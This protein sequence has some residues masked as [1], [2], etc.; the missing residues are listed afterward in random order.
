MAKKDGPVISVRLSL[1]FLP[2]AKT[3]ISLV[4]SIIFQYRTIL[5][6]IR[7]IHNHNGVIWGLFIFALCI[8][9][10]FIFGYQFVMSR[11]PL[12]CRQCIF[13]NFLNIGPRSTDF[14]SPE[15]CTPWQQRLPWSWF[16]FVILS[17][18]TLYLFAFLLT[19]FWSLLNSAVASLTCIHFVN[20]IYTYREIGLLFI[21][22]HGN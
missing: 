15:T 9:N 14:Q 1:I 5:Y 19:H 22:W 13:P 17:I 11:D 12:Q 10:F 2:R 4:S 6:S 3:S 18:Q 8:L 20:C 7:Y 16:G 21:L